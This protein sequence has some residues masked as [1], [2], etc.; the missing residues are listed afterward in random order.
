MIFI[1][2][3]FIIASYSVWTEENQLNIKL[4]E[5]LQNPVDYKIT[6]VF[7]EVE[8]SFDSDIL[9]SD[10]FCNSI[11]NKLITIDNILSKESNNNLNSLSYKLSALSHSTTK[12]SKSEDYY[13]KELSEYKDELIKFKD[14]IKTTNNNMKKN[15][16]NE[17][18][19][20]Y[21]VSLTIENIGR[22][23]DSDINI[24]ILSDNK[25]L[26][27][28]EIGD[29]IYKHQIDYPIEPEPP[30][31]IEL[32]SVSRNNLFDHNLDR[33]HNLYLPNAYRQNESIEENKIFTTLRDM[34]VGD[35]VLVV[36]NIL[37]MIKEDNFKMNYIIKSKE[38]E[39]IIEKDIE[40][41]Y[42][43]KKLIYNKTE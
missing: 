28:Y 42:D 10:E 19:K 31:S 20:I 32:F 14:N 36:K 21:S 4:Q 13:K 38:S 43:D 18:S 12:M 26:N 7:K 9:K 37:Y 5:K 30:K 33:L 15:I 41:Y 29:I 25:L 11:D 24:K 22:K 8:F 23:S 3:I 17:I 35:K 16:N 2:V 27:K 39:K 1:I 34:N 40:I 6:A